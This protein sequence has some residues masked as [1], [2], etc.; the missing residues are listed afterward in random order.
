MAEPFVGQII[1][2]GFNFAPAGWLQCDGSIVPISTYDVLFNL[3]GTIYGGN[4]VTTF[5]LPNLNGRVPL[6]MGQGLG[7]S[8]YVQGQTVGTEQVTL[9]AANMP[10]HTHGVSFSNLQGALESPKPVGGTNVAMG[11]SAIAGLPTGFYVT[12]KSGTVGLKPDAITVAGGSQPHEN[13]QQYLV[14]NYLIASAGIYPSQ[15]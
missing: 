6:G 8:N 10:A 9:T 5:G 3:L 4:G 15:G 12:G 11:T 2:V 7:L 14:L 13:R 1:S